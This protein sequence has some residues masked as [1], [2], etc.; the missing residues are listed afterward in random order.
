MHSIIGTQEEEKRI[1]TVKHGYSKHVYN[2][3]VL[4]AK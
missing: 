2:E 4:T 3:L 1:N